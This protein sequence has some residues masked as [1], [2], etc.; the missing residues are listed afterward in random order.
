[1]NRF[2]I[3]L[4]PLLMY[5]CFV[6]PSQAQSATPES[7]VGDFVKAWNSH[8]GKA[9]DPL[10]TDDAIW[11]PVA[12]ARTEG[13]SA[14]VKDFSEIHATWAKTTTVGGQSAMKVQQLRPDVAVVLF[15]LK[16]MEGGKE[17]PGID[18]AMVIVAVKEAGGWKIATGQ[19]TKQH[20]GA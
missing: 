19:I 8:D 18:R 2:P 20:E 1:M 3:L 13:R 11:V 4:V 12:E 10:F 9:F 14:I 16:F 15:H 6:T 17:V 7:L 5:I